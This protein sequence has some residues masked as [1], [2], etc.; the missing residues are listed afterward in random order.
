MFVSDWDYL[1]ILHEGNFIQ[2]VCM[3]LDEGEKLSVLTTEDYRL[4]VKIKP[5][6]KK[7]LQ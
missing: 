4:K 7:K 3:V 2:F 6:K 1:Q 5:V